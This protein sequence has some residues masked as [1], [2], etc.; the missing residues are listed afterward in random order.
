MKDLVDFNNRNDF[1]NYMRHLEKG[2]Y[3]Q[4]G[5]AK[6]PYEHMPAFPPK[7]NQ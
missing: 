1:E 7:P 5:F 6:P 4:L 2:Y 3:E